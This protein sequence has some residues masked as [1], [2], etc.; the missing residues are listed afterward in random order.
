[1]NTTKQS[2]GYKRAMDVALESLKRIE[3]HE[4]ECAE[5]WAEAIVEIK[6]LQELTSSHSLRWE[7]LAWLV[8]AAVTVHIISGMF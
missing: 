5:R 8:V 6:H 7:K 2:A 3:V 4:K 1:L